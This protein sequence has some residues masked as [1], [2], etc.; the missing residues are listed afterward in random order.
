MQY[1]SHEFFVGSLNNAPNCTT[2]FSEQEIFPKLMLMI[3]FQG[4]Q[5]FEID[6]VS[7]HLDVGSG[8]ARKPLVFML[9]IARY[10]KLRFFSQSDVPLRKVMISAP[11][12]WLR[13]QLDLQDEAQETTLRSFLTQH[14]ASYSFAPGQHIL[15]LAEKIMNPPSVAA[16]PL[17]T[18][19]LRVQGLDIMWQACLAMMAE[20]EKQPPVL[21]SANRQDCERIREFIMANLDRDLTIDLI[22]QKVAISASTVQRRFKKHYGTTLYNFIKQQR[23]EA[24]CVALS[25]DSIPIS[26]AAHLAGYNNTSTFTSAFRKLYGFS[27]QK[28]RALGKGDPCRSGSG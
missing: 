3:F 27:P 19:Y 1:T 20:K 12:S 13:N 5:H 25:R 2:D 10:S 11:H 28:M 7:F 17:A 8:E 16:G 9:N 4:M 21:S 18:L 26:Q 22:A 6:G 15:Q 14:L 24:A 23:L